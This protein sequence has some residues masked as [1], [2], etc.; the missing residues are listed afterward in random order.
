MVECWEENMFW[1]F[2]LILGGFAFAFFLKK[3][4]FMYLCIH[5]YLG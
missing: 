5:A 4:M 3:V 2:F 1:F